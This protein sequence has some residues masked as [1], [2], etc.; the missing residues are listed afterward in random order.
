[1]ENPFITAVRDLVGE[2]NRE[3]ASGLTTRKALIAL[4]RVQQLLEAMPLDAVA[5]PAQLSPV[6]QSKMPINSL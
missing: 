2:L 4:D 5:P 3:S 6:E 1:M